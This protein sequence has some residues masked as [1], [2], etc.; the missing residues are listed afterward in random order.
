MA[1][2]RARDRRGGLS[3]ACPGSGSTSSGRC[4]PASAASTSSGEPLLLEASGLEARVLQHE[5]DHLDGVLILDRT[6]RDQRKG[7]LRALREGTSYSPEPEPEPAEPGRRVRAVYF[8]TSDFAAAVL[9]RLA[10]EPEHRPALVVTPPDRRRGRGRKLGAAAG[11][12][13]GRG[14]RDRRSCAPRRPRRRRRSSGSAPPSP[15]SASSAPSASC[16]ASR[17]SPSSSCSTCTRRCCRAGAARRRSSGRSWPATRE[18]GVSIMRV[19]EGLDS[20]PVALQE[21]IAIGDDDY[22]GSRA[23]AR[24]A[25]LAAAGRGARAP[26]ARRARARRH[27]TTPRRPTPRRS[28]PASAGS[29][30]RRPRSSSSGGSGR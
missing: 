15:S 17:C 12:S 5:I 9:R 3:R 8:G 19:T 27:R 29:T 10:A 11:R 23:R 20:G 13:G 30:R 1:L 2:R 24:G 16:C 4:T 7:A 25:R 22:G 14:A 28:S 6:V 18:T 21:A 26:R